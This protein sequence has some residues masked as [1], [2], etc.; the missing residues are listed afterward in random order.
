MYALGERR[1]SGQMRGVLGNV[2]V[3]HLEA[4]DLAAVEVK[5]QVEIEPTLPIRLSHTT[6]KS[7]GPARTT[8]YFREYLDGA[9][10]LLTRRDTVLFVAI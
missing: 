2:G 9:Y 4:D 5:D 6:T 10:A 7:G 1:A 3:M 8:R